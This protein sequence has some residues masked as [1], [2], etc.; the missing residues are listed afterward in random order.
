[1]TASPT[2]TLNSQIQRKPDLMI[3][4]IDDELVMM[5][6]SQGKYFGLKGSG[7]RIWELIAEPITP[8]RI[9]DTLCEENDVEPATCRQDTLAF[10]EQLAQLELIT[11]RNANAQR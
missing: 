8:A 7:P 9:I 6:A 3:A 11:V 2:L 4:T 5:D 10:L 1:M